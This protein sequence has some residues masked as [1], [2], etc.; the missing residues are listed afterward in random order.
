M[1]AKLALSLFIQVANRFAATN[2]KDAHQPFRSDGLDGTVTTMLSSTPIKRSPAL[3]G[4]CPA[5]HCLEEDALMRPWGARDRTCRQQ[6]DHLFDSESE[7]L[8]LFLNVL[9]RRRWRIKIGTSC[10]QPPDV[11]DAAVVPDDRQARN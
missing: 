11:S 4:D 3:R 10:G 6:M 9:R 7:I 1:I 2:K 8:C 5:G